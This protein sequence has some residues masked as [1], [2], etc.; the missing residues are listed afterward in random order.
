MNSIAR[1]LAR[2]L[3]C[4]VAA[5]SRPLTDF[6]RVYSATPGA[7]VRSPDDDDLLQ[8]Y[9][10]AAEQCVPVSL[11]GS[12]HTCNGQTLRSE[13]L[14]DLAGPAQAQWQS[15]HALVS[16]AGRW[17]ETERILRSAKRQIPVLADHYGLSVGGTLSVGCYG[18]DS[19][20]HGGLVHNAEALR[21]ITPSGE[22]IWCSSDKH[23][24]LYASALA[25]LG[26]TGVIR[27]AK[28]RTVQRPRYTL[29]ESYRAC[30]LLELAE[31]AIQAPDTQADLFKA[32]HANGRY[33]ATYGQFA[34]SFRAVWQAPA[35]LSRPRFLRW[36]APDY[37]RIRSWAVQAWTARFPHRQNV[38]SDYLLPASGL[39]AFCRQLDDRLALQT[40]G[41]MLQAVYLLPIKNTGAQR[42]FLEGCCAIDEPYAYGI[43]LYGMAPE[44]DPGQLKR[45]RHCLDLC[46]QDA[47]TA[48]G[49]PYLYGYHRLD[50]PIMQHAFGS[51]WTSYKAACRKWDPTGV[52]S[53]YLPL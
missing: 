40:F 49:T 1:D 26:G 30:S 46:L 14:L 21:M 53:P 11:R 5:P 22:N 24:D 23:T 52:N 15:P 25:G 35:M 9:A 43:G 47:L 2:R 6:G 3:R 7:I 4:P 44:R 37:R 20:R 17:G 42:L 48:G 8:V 10:Y 27:E 29:L 36:I 16:A 38:W 31:L 13:I 45:L 50:E 28:I 39:L 33:V 12:G 18:A 41:N 51:G 32:L 19:M 34:D